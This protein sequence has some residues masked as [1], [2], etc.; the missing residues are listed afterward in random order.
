MVK[1]SPNIKYVQGT[2]FCDIGVEADG[3]SAVVMAAIDNLIKGGAGQ[4]V[5]CFNLIH[6][7]PET[8]GLN[9]FSLNP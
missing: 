4:A 2:N 1:G 8:A 5:Q 7:F 9:A 6:G 3:Q